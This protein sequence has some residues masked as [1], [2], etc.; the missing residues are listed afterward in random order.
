MTLSHRLPKFLIEYFNQLSKIKHL[1]NSKDLKME[2]PYKE[3]KFTRIL[4][5]DIR[6][7]RLSRDL[8]REFKELKNFYITEEQNK[9]LEKMSSIRKIIHLIIWMTKSLFLHLTPVRRL[10]TITALIIMFW[11]NQIIF[12]DGN[13]TVTNSGLLGGALIFIVLMLELKDKLL[14]KDELEAG[15]K[16]QRALMPEKSPVVPGWSI[17]LFTRPANEVGGDLV[18]YLKIGDDRIGLTIADVAGKGLHAALLMAKLQ[19]TIRAL[20]SDYESLS[21]LC[22][23]INQIF[24]RD[25]LP[26][27]F[28]SMF[29]FEVKP[30]DNVIKFVNAGHLPPLLIGNNEIKEI[31]QNNA[32][33][34]LAKNF[35]Y[36]EDLITMLAGDILIAYSDG[37][38]DAR[39]EYG[40]FYE[41]DNFLRLLKS[42]SKNKFEDIGEIIVKNIDSFSGDA[43][44]NDDLSLIIIRKE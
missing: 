29:Y 13:S 43:P 1:I 31:I 40:Q 6:N 24:C 3:Q 17:W 23:K 12:N 28:A 32:A 20:A 2:Q 14:A 35:T 5:E 18:D 38:T 33:I 22:N 44:S 37:V 25:S 26:N 36:K 34:G 30:N 9:R 42:I 16:V 41:K 21:D 4:R 7:V 10:L 19:S 27:I 15:R 11:G 39:N 8:K